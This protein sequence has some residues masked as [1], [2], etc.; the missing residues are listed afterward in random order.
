MK[1]KAILENPSPFR[2]WK[3]SFKDD[4]RFQARRWLRG[5]GGTLAAVPVKFVT[6]LPG[7]VRA[8]F[9]HLFSLGRALAPR[10]PDGESGRAARKGG[11]MH[12]AL[13]WLILLLFRTGD[14]VSLG[15]ALNFLMNLIKVETRPLSE[16]E[17]REARRVFGDSLDYWRIRIDEWSLIAHIGGWSYRRRWKKPADHMAMTLYSTIHFSRRIEPKPGSSDMDWLIHELTHAAQCEHAGGVFMVEA[18]IAQGEAGYNYGGPQGL[19]GRDFKDFN[20]EQQGDIARDYYR[21]LNDTMKVSPEERTEY[22]RMAAQLQAG[23][24]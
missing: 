2:T 23:Q 16:L 1:E 8:W 13:V 11:S 15:E 4:F 7:R 17:I 21:I 12:P 5:L 6:R 18:L 22:D 10:E 9:A 24:L 3:D 19:F 20:R 14:L